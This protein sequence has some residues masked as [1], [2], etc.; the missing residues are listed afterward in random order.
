[1]TAEVAVVVLAIL[2]RTGVEAGV[3]E[4]VVLGQP[5]PSALIAETRN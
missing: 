3:A 5:V 2:L 4:T 1:M